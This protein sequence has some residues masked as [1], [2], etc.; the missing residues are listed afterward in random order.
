MTDTL[1]DGLRSFNR[2]VTQRIGVLESEY[3]ARDRPLGQSR[4]LW[5]I[6]ENGCDIRELRARLGL[7]SG[8]LSR[9]LRAL[10][11][12]G[13]IDVNAADGDT[14]VR[15]ARLTSTGSA[16]LAELDRRSDDLAQS[17]LE[18]LSENQRRRLADAMAEVEKLFVASQVQIAIMNTRS[19]EARYCIRSYFEEIATRLENGFD[20]ALALPA[21]DAEP[22]APAGLFLVATL[23]EEPVGCG[24]LK[25]LRNADSIIEAA[26]IKRV[27]ISPNVR[28]MGLGK[29]I[30]AELE[31]QA[32]AHGA[33]AIRL[34]TNR[35]LTEAIAMY[36][37]AGYDEVAAFNE[38]KY[39]HHWFEK[40]LDASSPRA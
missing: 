32:A 3:L 7:D 11:S 10:E 17:I 22:S 27:W 6:G 28:G 34:D 37:S 8:Y 33:Q 1:V 18:P 20:P 26:E 16:E 36:R 29:R 21:G 13:L 19:P 9:L 4:V 35:A 39:A 23:H 5:E 38:E 15:T 24:G 40:R 30:L 12:A 2:T 14:R 25:L 31:R